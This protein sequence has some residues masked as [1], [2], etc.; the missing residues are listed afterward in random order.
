MKLG[1]AKK[2]PAATAASAGAKKAD[3]PKLRLVTPARQPAILEFQADA[4]ELEERKPPMLARLTLYAVVACIGCAVYWASVSHIDEIVV[5]PG[6][7]VTTDPVLVVQPLETSVIRSIDV[8]AGDIVHK[9]QPLATLDPTFPAS[10]V[11]QLQAKIAGFDAQI[12]RLEAEIAGKLYV[13]PADPTADEVTQAS[14]A[15]Q[16]AAFFT[17]RLNDFDAQIAHAQAMAAA[18]NAQVAVLDQRL[19]GL[20]EIDDMHAS[21]AKTGSGSRLTYLQGRDVSLDTQTTLSQVR[22][23]LVESQKTAEQARAQRQTFIE[24]Y[25][26]TSMETLIDLKDKQAGASEELKKALLRKSMAVMVAPA[27][28]AV[29]DIAQRS[30]GSVVKEAEPLFSLVPLN[31]PL[32]AEVSVA[33]RDIGHLALNDPARIKFDAFPF[34]KHGTLEGK[35]LSISQDSFSPQS[36][37]GSGGDSPAPAAPYYKVR[38]ALGPMQLKALPENF[39]L[40]PGLT[41]E[42]E[43]NAGDRSVIS[44]FLYPLLRGLDESLHE[45]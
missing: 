4:I 1:R 32:E 13:A 6:K 22:G 5:A 34:Q 7:V 23:D 21:L 43:I 39:R 28:A 18:D 20:Q 24:D 41:V 27:D 36:G 2:Q 3:A 38:I 8:K 37:S 35:V 29:L 31:V 16:R 12:A 44:Y 42:A 17:A 14:L 9:G 25:R 19:A 15:E 40:L 33:A 30:I 26:R 10:D 45:P 11:D